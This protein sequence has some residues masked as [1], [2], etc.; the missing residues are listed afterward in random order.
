V[1]NDTNIVGLLVPSPIKVF[2]EYGLLPGLVLAGFL[3]LCYWGGPSRAFGLS[4]LASLWLLQ[5]GT[6]TMVIVAPLLVFVSL[7]SPR[8]GPPIEELDPSTPAA[9]HLPVRSTPA[10]PVCAVASKGVS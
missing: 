10:P 6:T 5:P 3:L 1:V 8:T 4:L 2:F 9:Q 7:W